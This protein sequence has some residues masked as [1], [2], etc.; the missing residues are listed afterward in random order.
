MQLIRRGLPA[1]Q[2]KRLRR[3]DPPADTDHRNAILLGGFDGMFQPIFAATCPAALSACKIAEHARFPQDETPVRGWCR[4]LKC[5]RVVFH[6]HRAMRVD[7]SGIGVNNT[8]A[9]VAA[10]SRFNPAWQSLSQLAGGVF[11]D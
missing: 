5:V 9:T 7:P 4:L 11:P 8:S 3:C 10:C 1:A 2:N 6:A